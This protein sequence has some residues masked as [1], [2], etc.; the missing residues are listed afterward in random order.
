MNCKHESKP[1]PAGPLPRVDAPGNIRHCDQ[2]SEHVTGATY[3]VDLHAAAGHRDLAAQ[4]SDEDF[5][6]V[7]AHVVL[8]IGSPIED[9]SRCE[10]GIRAREL[11][12]HSALAVREL[13]LAFGEPRVT[14]RERDAKWTDAPEGLAIRATTQ[15]RA[16]ASDEL[17]WIARARDD[18]IGAKL[19]ERE[20]GR[21]IRFGR[22]HENRHVSDGR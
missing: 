9:R 10:T 11:D 8:L 16:D 4:A 6:H 5:R 7:R 14:G 20:P 3:R 1:L 19:E 12:E 15:D 13:E 22:E 18:I 2:R 17:G 21:H